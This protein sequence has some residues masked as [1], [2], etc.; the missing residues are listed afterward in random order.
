M[1]IHL[2]R[3]IFKIFTIH[4]MAT[5]NHQPSNAHTHCATTSQGRQPTPVFLPGKFHGQRSLADY[6]PWGPQRA[7]HNLVTKQQQA[8]DECLWTHFVKRCNCA[9]EMLLE[10]GEYLFLEYLPAQFCWVYAALG[11]SMS[12]LWSPSTHF[13]HSG[14][15]CFLRILSHVKKIV[16]NHHH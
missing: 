15:P 3:C 1:N 10:L 13:S 8:L 16:Q 7:R 2:T 5:G 9:S 4:L 11:E 14:F 12:L 6:S